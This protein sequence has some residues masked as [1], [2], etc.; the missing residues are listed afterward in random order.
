[1][2]Q[3]ERVARRQAEPVGAERKRA[4]QGLPRA[5]VAIAQHDRPLWDRSVRFA[6][7]GR[8]L[9]PGRTTAGKPAAL[10]AIAGGAVRT[11]SEKIDLGFVGR[12]DE[13]RTA[14]ARQ[15]ARK[16]AKGKER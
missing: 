13:P 3:I 1:M 5:A 11:G 7:L 16:L 4:E 14:Q 15:F 8:L 12:Q 10:Q 6:H 9:D 2:N